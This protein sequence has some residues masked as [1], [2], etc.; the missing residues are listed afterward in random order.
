[1]LGGL[2]WPLVE[3]AVRAGYGPLLRRFAAFARDYAG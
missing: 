3:P 2:G 1:V